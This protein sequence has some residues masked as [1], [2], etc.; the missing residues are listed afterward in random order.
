MHKVLEN[1]LT[2][3][4]SIIL[5][6]VAICL[7]AIHGAQPSLPIHGL[8]LPEQVQIAT[9]PSMPPYPWEP[10]NVKTGPS[11]PSYPWEPVATA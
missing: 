3:G 4:V 5:F 6:L 11:M 1:R 8:S 7:C 10:V 9:G 2:A